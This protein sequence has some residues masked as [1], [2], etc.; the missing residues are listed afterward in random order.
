MTFRRIF[1][2]AAIAMATVALAQKPMSNG[3]GQLKR[4][5]D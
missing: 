2:L 4:P 1:L 5:V 3:D